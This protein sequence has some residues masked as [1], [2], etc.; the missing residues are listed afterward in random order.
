MTMEKLT[1]N[2]DPENKKN[3]PVLNVPAL[4]YSKNLVLKFLYNGLYKLLVSIVAILVKVSG[5]NELT[6][7]E[8]ALSMK[9]Q[10]TLV[11]G[12]WIVHHNALKLE[13]IDSISSSVLD[14]VLCWLR[15]NIENCVCKYCYA[16]NQQKVQYAL[17]EHGIINGLILRNC[18]LSVKALKNLALKTL[19]V[20]IESF[21]DVAN[22][23]QARN[24]IRIIKA[25]PRKHFAIWSKNPGIWKRAFDLEGKPNNCTYVHSSSKVNVIDNIDTEKYYFVDHIFT[26]FTKAYATKHGIVINCGGRKCMECIKHKRNC[27]FRDGNLYINELKK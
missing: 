14:N 8:N 7:T 2:H 12:I 10:I 27:Y 25:F 18:L 24:Y 13:G 1:I 3:V 17:C 21:G 4:L 9:D 20:R 15:R 5:Y 22:V 23:I 26:V 16:A 19:F 6:I 11:N